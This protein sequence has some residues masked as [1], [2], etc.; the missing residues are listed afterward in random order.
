MKALKA[1]V[2]TAAACLSVNIGFS[3]V[4]HLTSANIPLKG[5][6]IGPKKTLY[7]KKN[8]LINNVEYEVKCQ[9]V[10][11][12]PYYSDPFF[13]R[14]I[15]MYSMRGVS[16]SSI[17]DDHFT[18]ENGQGAISS[19]GH[20]SKLT[21]LRVYRSSRNKD[22]STGNLYDIALTNLDLTRSLTVKSCVA[23]PS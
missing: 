8:Q 21:I 20:P 17:I 9:V 11:S 14:I 10:S 1:L 2:V 16:S 13:I 3:A 6:Y 7:I 4:H 12:F 23:S 22:G 19:D 15:P 18:N 5:G